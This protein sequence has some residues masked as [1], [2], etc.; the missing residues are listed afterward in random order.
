MKKTLCIILALLALV[1]LFAGCGEKPAAPVETSKPSDSTND[2]DTNASAALKDVEL[3]TGTNIVLPEGYEWP[4]LTI[5]V[6]DYN[7]MNSGPATGTQIAV[8]HIEEVSGGKVKCEVHYGGT[9]MESTD[10]FAGTAEGLA[11]ITYYIYTLNSGVSTLHSL[12]CAMYT[13]SMPDILGIFEC[14]NTTLDTVPQFREEFT[15][16]NLYELCCAPTEGN[17]LEFNN[18]ELGMSVKTPADLD[19]RLVQAS[20]Y[21]TPAWAAYGVSGMSMPPADWYTN[22]ERGVVD[23]LSMNLPGCSDF[24]LTDITNC[25]ITFGNNV[26]LYNSAAGYFANLDKWNSWD[27]QVQALVKEGFYLGAKASAEADRI[28][29]QTTLDGEIAAGKQVNSISE[30]DMNAW[31]EM[32]ELSVGFWKDD[33]VA[34]GYDPDVLYKGYMDVIDAYMANNK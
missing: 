32:A 28:R 19:G 22:L 7:P 18:A 15:K 29:A 12:F 20:G 26:G 2:K 8:D 24:G 9:L 33:V 5:V 6:N 16:Q 21:N 34:A 1:S 14:I 10:S 23:A 13:R 4:E 30:D 17:I 25:Y 11:D 3:D 31:Y 27:P